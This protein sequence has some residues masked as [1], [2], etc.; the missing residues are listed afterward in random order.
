MIHPERNMS[1]FNYFI[2]Q[3]ESYATKVGVAEAKTVLSSLLDWE[4]GV[5]VNGSLEIAVTHRINEKAK[6]QRISPYFFIDRIF[7]GYKSPDRKS[8]V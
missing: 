6:T 7:Y 2:S 1:L 8:V 4:K 5:K 3:L